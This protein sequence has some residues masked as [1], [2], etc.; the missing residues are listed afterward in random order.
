MGVEKMTA[1]G[2]WT[3]DDRPAG[4]SKSVHV[5]DCG[6]DCR[7]QRAG[8]EFHWVQWSASTNT[9]GSRHEAVVEAVSGH[10][11]VVRMQDT[12]E[13]ET[14]WHH[15]SLEGVLEVGQRVV[16]SRVFAFLKVGP[17]DDALMISVKHLGSV[18][19]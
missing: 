1:A 3:G 19:R 11:C 16:R 17:D 12:G 6:P 9:P 15:R 10:S 18:D 7:L 5:D 8:H 4:P 13:A 2:A 14:L